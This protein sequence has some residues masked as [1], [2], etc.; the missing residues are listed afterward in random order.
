MANTVGGTKTPGW[1]FI[2][3]SSSNVHEPGRDFIVEE[4][5]FKTPE[6]LINALVQEVKGRVAI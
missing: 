5:D 3:T 4:W 6:E 2:Y 1:S